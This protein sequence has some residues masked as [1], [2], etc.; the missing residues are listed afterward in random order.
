MLQCE[1]ELSGDSLPSSSIFRIISVGRYPGVTVS[2][3]FSRGVLVSLLLD[4]EQKADKL[5]QGE[6]KSCWRP[7]AT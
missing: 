3:L 2:G 7:A 4:G 5:S 6:P 1:D